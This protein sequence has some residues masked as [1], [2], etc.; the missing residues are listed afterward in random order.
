MSDYTRSQFDEAID[1]LHACVEELKQIRNRQGY[2]I[3]EMRTVRT[4]LLRVIREN[5]D[6]FACGHMPEKRHY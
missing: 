1:V 2:T 5:I 6:P 3:N 4:A